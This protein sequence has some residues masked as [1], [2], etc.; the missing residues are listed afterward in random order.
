MMST[1]YYTYNVCNT[2]S[3]QVEKVVWI[4]TT[5]YNDVFKKVIHTIGVEKVTMME[6]ITGICFCFHGLDWFR[7]VSQ[8]LFLSIPVLFLGV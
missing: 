6:F 5:L 7:L 2:F 4:M 3:I 1:G 8:V